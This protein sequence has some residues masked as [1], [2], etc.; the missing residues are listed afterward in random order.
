MQI[1]KTRAKTI[2]NQIL[3][4]FLKNKKKTILEILSSY[5][6]VTINIKIDLNKLYTTIKINMQQIY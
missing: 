1:K 5:L 3:Q 2:N 6:S 4:N